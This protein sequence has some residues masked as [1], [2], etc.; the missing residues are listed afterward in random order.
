MSETALQN[1]HIAIPE[2]RQLDVLAGLLERRGAQVLRCPLVGI[3]DTPNVEQVRCWLDTAIRDPF[4][5][6]VLLTGEGLRRLLSFSERYGWRDDFIAA[7]SQMRTI[8]RGPKPA[9][10]LRELGLKAHVSAVKPTTAGVMASLSQDHLYGRRMGVQLYGDDPNLPLKAHLDQ[11]GAH[12]FFVAPYRYADEAQDT[13]VLDLI[14]QM[15][16]GRLDAICFTSTP[17]VRRL[18]SV[19]RKQG[20]LDEFKQA[21]TGVVVASVGPIV[22]E[23]LDQAG[24]PADLMPSESFFMKPLVQAL[25]NHFSK[26]S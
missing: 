19:A 20:R 26:A 12:G 15:I 11:A 14:D 25:V 23:T 4:D 8:V 3:L 24:I 16:N 21:M 9:K 18:L 5:D 1:R 6:L 22:S 7:L 13:Q 2:T 17:Q 10:V